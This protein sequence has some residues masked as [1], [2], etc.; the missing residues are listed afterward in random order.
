MREAILQALVQ[1]EPTI[2][3]I[4]GL[5]TLCAAIWGIV[6]LTVA[7]RKNGTAETVAPQHS[8][9]PTKRFQ[10][11]SL[12][13][14]GLSEHSKLEELVSVRTVNVVFLCLLGFSLPWM[15]VSLLTLKN[16]TLSF[17]TLSVFVIALLGL[18]LQHS[19]A[20]SS[21]R[22]LLILGTML[23]WLGIMLTLGPMQGTEYFLAALLAA[24]VLIF[25]RVQI[26][27]VILSSLFVMGM[28][29]LGIF[30]THGNPPEQTLTDETLRN[31]YNINALF[32]AGIIFAVVGY[33][34]NFAA[35]SYQI[36][37]DQKHKNDQL[38]SRLFPPDIAKQMVNQEATAAQWHSDATVLYATLTGFTELYA[39]LP[40]IDLVTKLDEL[41]SRFDELIDNHHIDKV[42]TLG[43]T[44]V[45]AT[46]IG[47]APSEH[48]AIAETG[49]AMRAVVA[50]FA[51]EHS[52]PVGF[53][54]GIATGLTI[55]GVIGKSRPR[56]DIWGEALE[57]AA[58]L[59]T[60]ACEGEI[61]VNETAYWRLEE[62][63][64]FS[65]ED[66]GSPIAKSLI[67]KKKI[68]LR[69]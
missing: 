17:L 33:Y 30:L 44:Y 2:S 29:C 59:Q 48:S 58:S 24:P 31:V 62:H 6:R 47:T 37:T 18:A 56:F 9:L 49:I 19:G 4:V 42:K 35:S 5:L 60:L 21:A 22:W 69:P 36:L 1:Y 23:Y 40:A 57:A 66:R 41:Y 45:A 27:Q 43:T 65:P 38:V 11:R 50:A 53:R 28:F 55:S 52:L 3:S 32:L 54:C 16:A 14:L 12:I 7:K 8:P 10:W 51:S 39:R 64:D 15:I 61:L 67:A 34:K 46:G 25:S 26:G 13:N 20:T 63:F 68:E